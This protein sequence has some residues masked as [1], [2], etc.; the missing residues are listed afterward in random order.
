MDFLQV[1]KDLLIVQ[2]QPVTDAEVVFREAKA[3]SGFR[4][5]SRDREIGA[6]DLLPAEQVADRFDRLELEIKVGFEVQFH[7]L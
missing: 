2:S 5:G 4:R 7:D 6:T 1:L 3:R